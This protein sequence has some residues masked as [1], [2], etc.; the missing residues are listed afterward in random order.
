MKT[1]NKLMILTSLCFIILHCSSQ[2]VNIKVNGKSYLSFCSNNYLGLANHPNVKAAFIKA[3]K[4]YGI[5]VIPV[6]FIIDKEGII[7]EKIL[8]TR[9]WDSPEIILL[10][11][12]WL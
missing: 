5:I 6:T 3:A 8:G 10:I 1:V 2:D 11:E 9:E 12:K 7:R 4:K